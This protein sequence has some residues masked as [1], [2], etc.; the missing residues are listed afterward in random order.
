DVLSRDGLHVGISISLGMAALPL[1][2]LG[3][4]QWHGMGL[5]ARWELRWRVVCE[6]L[7]D[8][9]SGDSANIGLDACYGSSFAGR[10]F[11]QDDPRRESRDCGV[12]SRR[13]GTA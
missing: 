1:W 5:V 3:L 13:T 6:Q 7:P 9:S 11:G 4:H 12:Y 10:Q 8:D 2:L